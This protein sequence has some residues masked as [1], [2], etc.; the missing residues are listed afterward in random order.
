MSAGRT[1]FRGVLGRV[2]LGQRSDLSGLR[3]CVS[4]SYNRKNSPNQRSSSS[5]TSTKRYTHTDTGNG[6][7][8]GS[9]T[10]AGSGKNVGESFLSKLGVAY[11]TLLG[12]NYMSNVWVHPTAKLD[13]GLMNVLYLD[14][15]EVVNYNN[16]CILCIGKIKR[17]NLIE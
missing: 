14:D 11:V 3:K 7:R 9:G 12:A 15:R 4:R 17:G 1:L 6:T 2:W 16:T 8:S 13:Y 10:E 5:S